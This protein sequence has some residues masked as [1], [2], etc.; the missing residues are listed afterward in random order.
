MIY[1][2]TKKYAKE[3][4]AKNEKGV[5]QPIAFYHIQE[6]RFIVI[7]NNSFD[8]KELSFDNKKEAEKYCKKANLF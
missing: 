5:A 3:F 7:D 2:K 4:I 6:N 8:C 1:E